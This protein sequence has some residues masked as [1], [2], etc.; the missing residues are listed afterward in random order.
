MKRTLLWTIPVLAVVGASVLY[1]S[2]NSEKLQPQAPQVPAP[3]PPAIRYPIEA[4]GPPP[5]P[6][7]A[8]TESDGAIRDAL[9]ALFGKDLEKFFNLQ[10]IIRRIVATIDNLP[11]DSVSLLLMPVKPLPG[12]LVTTGTGESLALSP[13]NAARYRAYVRLAEAVPTQALVAVYRRFYPLFQKQ[14]ENLGYTEKYFNDRVVEVID[15]LLEAPDVHRLV[16]LS[17]PRVLYEFADPKLERLSAGQ[18]ILLR[19]GRENA[20]EMKAK[21]REIREALVSKVTSG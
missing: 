8:L 5:E 7:P 3:A 16:L 1:F 2:L 20:V 21:L 12:L 19:M 9:A 13:R 14:Y 11:R 18:K 15:H 10:D 4:D 6:L 17:Q